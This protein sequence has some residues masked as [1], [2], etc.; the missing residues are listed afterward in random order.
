MVS[1]NNALRRRMKISEN[2]RAVLYF[3][4]VSFPLSWSVLQS[5]RSC[6]SWCL[7]RNFLC[8]GGISSFGANITHTSK[9][10]CGWY[11]FDALLANAWFSEQTND[12]PGPTVF[13]GELF[14]VALLILTNAP[15]ET[16]PC[17]CSGC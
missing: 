8:L 9:K 17:P 6:M 1:E 7:S 4:L 2:L 14:G 11:A 12:L 16:A 10:S 3:S 13:A 15:L 5:L